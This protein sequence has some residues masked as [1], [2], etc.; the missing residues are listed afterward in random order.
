MVQICNEEVVVTLK[1]IRN[2]HL[3]V[4][5]NDGTILVTA[6][7]RS[8]ASTIE[9]FV[10][11]HLD[12]VERQRE[13]LNERP[14]VDLISREELLTHSL[15]LAAYWQERIGV[16]AERIRLRQ[17]KTRWGVCNVKSRIITINTELAKYPSECLEYVMVHEL[18]H[19][20]VAAHNEKFWN[21]VSEQI[22][23]YKI[24]RKMLK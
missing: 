12:W 5:P 21:I 10:S 23:D 7:I 11:S 16:V 9:K 13:K 6:P 8:S 3:R 2:L 24:W 4:R 22:P 17:M 1:K 15:E 19:L 14:T 18:A 20:K